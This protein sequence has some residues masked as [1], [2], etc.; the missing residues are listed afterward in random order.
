MQSYF[1]D[2]GWQAEILVR[3]DASAALAMASRQ[4]IG[5]A[6]HLQVRRLWFQALV[7]AGAV[8]VDVAKGKLKPADFLTKIHNHPEAADRLRLVGLERS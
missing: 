1:N 2:L 7:K 4:G 5:Q 3:A 8:H 6:R